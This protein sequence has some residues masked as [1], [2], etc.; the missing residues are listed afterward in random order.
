MNLSPRFV[1]TASAIGFITLDSGK[2]AE[3]QIIITRDEDAFICE[4]V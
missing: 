1:D 2:K 4:D 3:V